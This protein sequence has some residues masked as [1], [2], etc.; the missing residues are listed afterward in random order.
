MRHTDRAHAPEAESREE[1]SRGER[2]NARW[3]QG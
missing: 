2:T 1:G 3:K